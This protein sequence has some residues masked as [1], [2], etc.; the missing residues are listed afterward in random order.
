VA[1]PPVPKIFISSQRNGG[2]G[3]GG[4]ERFADKFDRQLGSSVIKEE[5]SRHRSAPSDGH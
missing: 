2:R 5:M 3:D 4:G 1:V